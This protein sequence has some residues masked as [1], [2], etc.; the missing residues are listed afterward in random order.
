MTLKG[1]NKK[2][3]LKSLH[4]DRIGDHDFFGLTRFLEAY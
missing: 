1:S 2:K 4:S 3:L